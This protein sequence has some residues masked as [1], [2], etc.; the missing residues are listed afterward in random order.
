MSENKQ[1][2]DL[3][4][5]LTTFARQKDEI[6]ADYMRLEG[7]IA[8]LTARLNKIDPNWNVPS[9]KEVSAKETQEK[10]K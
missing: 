1:L 9:N 8:Y 4:K 10:K 7:I 2:E 5:E 6:F 3:K